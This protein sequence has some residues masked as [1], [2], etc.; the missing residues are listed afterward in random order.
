MKKGGEILNSAIMECCG[1][2]DY[3]NVVAE[4]FT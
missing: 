4:D 3:I 2:S 1:G